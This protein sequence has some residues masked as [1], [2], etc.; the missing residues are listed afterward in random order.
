[1]KINLVFKLHFLKKLTCFSMRIAG[2]LKMTRSCEI[3]YERI[4]T[5]SII[6]YDSM[7]SFIG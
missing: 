5:S 1:M 6:F 2:L 7:Y 4:F 3:E